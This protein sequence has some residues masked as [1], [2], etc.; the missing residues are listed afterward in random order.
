MSTANQPKKEKGGKK[1]HWEQTQRDAFSSDTSATHKYISHEASA[2]PPLILRSAEALKPASEWRPV[3][4]REKGKKKKKKKK[5]RRRGGA[6]VG[7][8]T[9][10][11]PGC[12]KRTQRLVLPS[13][14]VTA[15]GSLQEEKGFQ[16]ST[17]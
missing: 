17:V 6:E 2:A 7:Y 16:I 8:G 15:G 3:T 9:Q 14:G 11:A 5:A 10:S 4:Q 13:G 1:A 12:V